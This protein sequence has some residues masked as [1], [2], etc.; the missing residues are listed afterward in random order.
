MYIEKHKNEEAKNKKSI[1]I[2]RQHSKQEDISNV[3]SKKIKPRCTYCFHKKKSYFKLQPDLR[4]TCMKPAVV[5]STSYRRSFKPEEIKNKKK[6]V[7]PLMGK[8]R[9][10][11]K[12]RF[13]R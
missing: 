8:A 12:N 7:A 4:C 6:T 13:R 1:C 2:K 11:L 10:Q 9:Q 5:G 3:P